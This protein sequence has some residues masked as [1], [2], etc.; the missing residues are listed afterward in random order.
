VEPGG[1][2]REVEERTL[3]FKQPTRP[4][5]IESG[6]GGLTRE[7]EERTLVFKPP[8]L[9]TG[10]TITA[11]IPFC[12]SVRRRADGVHTGGGGPTALVWAERGAQREQRR[13]RSRAGGGAGSRSGDHAGG[14]SEATGCESWREGFSG[15]RSLTRPL[16]DARRFPSTRWYRVPGATREP[17][18]FGIGPSFKG[19][20]L[21]RRD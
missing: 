19:R 7:V 10:V 16:R 8:L 5:D 6:P 17:L 9:Q 2:T 12:T 14:Y 3:V 4:Y 15:G 21:S 20:F 11:E 18:G 1:L 13:R